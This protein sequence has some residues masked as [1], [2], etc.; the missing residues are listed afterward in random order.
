MSI[1][2]AGILSGLT[3]SMGLGGGFILIIYLTVFAGMG[4]TQA[5]GVNLLFFLPVALISVVLHLKNRLIDKSVLPR[6]CLFG[7]IGVVPGVLL[8]AF[9]PEDLLK[10]LFACLILLVGIREIFHKPNP[11]K[12][13]SENADRLKIEMYR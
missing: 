4:Q 2:I 8:A 13:E 12:S 6:F 9:A 5:A 7:I 3:A 1:I 11:A 10:N